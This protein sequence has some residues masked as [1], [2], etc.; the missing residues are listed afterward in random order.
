MTNA[1]QDDAENVTPTS[2]MS[3]PVNEGTALDL[4]AIPV[5]YKMARVDDDTLREIKTFQDAFAV[6]GDEY[7]PEDYADAYGTGFTVLTKASKGR[8][9]G[10]DMVMLE[11]RFTRSAEFKGIFVSVELVTADN[12]KFI[13]NDGSETGICGQLLKVTNSRL[14]RGATPEQAMRGLRV[15]G[16]LR[17]STYET[18]DAKGEQITATTYYLAN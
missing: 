8:L 2:A 7:I 4:P 10:V 18:T 14:A 1:S 16:G 3:V 15:R 17:E 9:E 6:L 11:W 13:L 5:D 12:A